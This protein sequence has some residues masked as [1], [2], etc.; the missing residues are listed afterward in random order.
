M[1][2]NRQIILMVAMAVFLVI[3]GPFWLARKQAASLDQK[4]AGVKSE[5]KGLRTKI[6]QAKAVKKNKPN[7]TAALDAAHA[8]MPSDN[9]IKGAIV[10]LQNLAEATK[11]EWVSFSIASVVKPEVKGAPKTTVAPKEATTTTQAKKNAITTTTKVP[12]TYPVGGF[13]INVSV[14]GTRSDI[15]SY[16]GKIRNLPPPARLFV[17]S[18]VTMDFARGGVANAGVSGDILT[19]AQLTLH[20]VGFGAPPTTV[21]EDGAA[22]PKTPVTS[23]VAGQTPQP[24]A[25]A[26]VAPVVTV[27]GTTPV[28]VPAPVQ[29]EPASTTTTTTTA[30]PAPPDSEA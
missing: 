2:Q 26:T 19:D 11:V 20:A 8:A 7:Y 21:A 29:I 13:D 5:A 23:I 30:D 27:A 1:K 18:G 6:D 3:G 14:R 15:L 22:T 12:A 28:V 17:V 16:L 4:T 9:D 25:V 24:A 10:T